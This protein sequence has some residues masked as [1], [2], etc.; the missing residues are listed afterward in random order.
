ME[1]ELI[2]TASTPEDEAKLMWILRIQELQYALKEIIALVKGAA[3]GLQ[4][5]ETGQP[6]RTLNGSCQKVIDD[7]GLRDL[8]SD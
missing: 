3:V 7:L 2:I 6:L 8:L 5:T 1:M 4:D